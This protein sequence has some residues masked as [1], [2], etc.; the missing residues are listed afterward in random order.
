MLVKAID[1]RCVE[2]KRLYKLLQMDSEQSEEMFT[3]PIYHETF[4]DVLNAE[5]RKVNEIKHGQL[6]DLATRLHVEIDHWRNMC[7][8]GDKEK[9]EFNLCNPA[10]ITDEIYDLHY[11]YAQSLE[12]FYKK[13][14][15]L[16]NSANAWIA[17]WNEFLRF[18][19]DYSDPSRFRNKNY[20]SL[21]E[22][23]L[24]TGFN[25]ELPRIEKQLYKE[26]GEFKE[27]EKRD[28]TIYGEHF[29]EYIVA[30]RNLYTQS[31]EEIKQD[32]QNKKN[33]SVK[34]EPF[35]NYARSNTPKTPHKNLYA[36]KDANSKGATQSNNKLSANKLAALNTKP[37]EANAVSNS[38]SKHLA[39]SMVKVKTELSDRKPAFS[40][41]GLAST[42]GKNFTANTG[43]HNKR[44][45]R[46]TICVSKRP[47]S[48]NRNNLTL[49]PKNNPVSRKVRFIRYL[50]VYTKS[51]GNSIGLEKSHDC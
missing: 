9:A 51:L 13:H 18:D 11:N 17:M 16:L 34:K 39:S 1:E 23:K 30:R 25:I 48:A 27:A 20:S 49:A 33:L 24:R 10:D 12:A 3:S 31:K 14:A 7:L 2:L 37:Q 42:H 5:L 4:L 38:N 35:N 32:R 22:A 45:V 19:K 44:Y 21:Q 26:A 6:I 28:F 8:F 15:N 40:A 29:N 36:C 43:V 41:Y 50:S 47:T 46:S